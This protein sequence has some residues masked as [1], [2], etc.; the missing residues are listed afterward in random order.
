[1]EHRDAGLST[2]TRVTYTVRGRSGEVTRSSCTGTIAGKPIFDRYTME[3]WIPVQPDG[4]S[5][6]VEPRLIRR[7]TI[8]EVAG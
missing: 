4:A 3:V 6:D 7:E 1:M 8:I 2:G 5:E